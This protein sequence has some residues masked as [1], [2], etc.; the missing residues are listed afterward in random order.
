MSQLSLNTAIIGDEI[1]PTG[2]FGDLP[3]PKQ[4]LTEPTILRHNDGTMGIDIGDGSWLAYPFEMRS[5]GTGVIFSY[6]LQFKS[7]TIVVRSFDKFFAGCQ[8]AEDAYEAI[9]VHAKA[10]FKNIENDR[11]VWKRT[12]I[13]GTRVMQMF[14]TI[15]KGTRVNSN[16]AY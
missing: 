2:V 16:V 14:H 11:K 1:E 6:A 12:Y 8:T 13:Q 7:G 10:S 4:T 9:K 3:A 15:R 5:V